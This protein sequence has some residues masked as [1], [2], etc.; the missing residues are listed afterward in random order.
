MEIPGLPGESGTG[1]LFIGLRTPDRP[2]PRLADLPATAGAYAL[3]FT[4]EAPRR[5]AVRSLGNPLLTAGAYAYCGNAHGPGGLRA[6]VMRHLA[7]DKR[8]HWHVD[9]LAAGECRAVAIRPG[10]SE[11]GLVDGF[12]AAGASVPIPG[13]GSS[14]CRRCP[15][16][17]VRLDDDARSSLCAVI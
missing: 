6:R 11:C 13:F 12:L 1:T 17:L 3:Y 5:L 14:D 2:P 8:Q 16:H 4:I 10:S 15:A 7:P 9:H